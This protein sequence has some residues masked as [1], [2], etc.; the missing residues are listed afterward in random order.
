MFSGILKD[1]LRELP[2][3]LITRTLY[4][5]VREAMTL[6]PPPSPPAAPDPLLAQSTVDLLS[7]LPPP[8]RVTTANT[9]QLI[10]RRHEVWTSVSVHSRQIRVNTHTGD[11][12]LMKRQ[13]TDQSIINPVNKL[14]L[15]CV[16]VNE[17]K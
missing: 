16:K 4:E 17:M 14:Q 1:Y 5:V 9:V 15:F 10:T 13:H 11:S 6:R 12:S 3:Q 2:S 7:C 8:E